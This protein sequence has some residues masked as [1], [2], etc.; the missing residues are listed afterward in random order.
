[1]GVFKCQITDKPGSVVSNHLSRPYIA[2]W[3]ERF[4]RRGTTGPSR[5][6]GPRLLAADRVYLLRTSPYVAV[7]SY[8]AKLAPSR[9][10]SHPPTS[11]HSFHLFLIL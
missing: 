7:S 1:M 2:I 6:R 11:G 10:T 8:L 3:F 5:K 4:Y 9:R